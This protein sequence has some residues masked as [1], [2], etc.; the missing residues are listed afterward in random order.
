MV[1]APVLPWRG[2]LT[3]LRSVLDLVRMG[4]DRVLV[5]PH[6]FS[7]F[8]CDAQVLSLAGLALRSRPYNLYLKRLYPL[9]AMRVRARRRLHRGFDGQLLLSPWGV[10]GVEDRRAA[11]HQAAAQQAMH[12]QR[13]PHAF[14][15]FHP[16]RL[17]TDLGVVHRPGSAG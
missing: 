12:Q 11:R 13:T 2:A 10:A 14:L 16:S 6:A 15:R 1:V 4:K 9:T 7:Y 17:G 5:S 3:T 8:T